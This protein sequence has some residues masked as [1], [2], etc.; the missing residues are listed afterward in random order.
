MYLAV[1]IGGT[2]TLVALLSDDGQ[3]VE[4]RRFQTDQDYQQF[5]TELRQNYA[6]LENRPQE[7]I[8]G[9]VGVP[10]A[11]DRDNGIVLALGN[12]PWQHKPIRDDIAA[13]TG[14]RIVIE[15]DAN[16]AGLSEAMLSK[17]YR[18]VL[19]FTV[20]TGI[21][22]GLIRDQ[23]IDPAFIKSEGG[24]IVLPH[25]GV[26]TDWEH[27]AS[28]K[29][30]AERYGKPAS[31]ITNENDWRAIARDLAPG[32]F[33]HIAI[34]QPDLIVIGGSIGT[35]FEHYKG[36]LLEELA[37]FERPVVPVPPITEAQRPEEAVVFGCYDL[38]RQVFGNG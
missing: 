24:H 16:L 12:L 9:G 32:F 21:G 30:I 37:A 36:Y 5:I 26:L 13:I 29:A 7:P 23:Q 25:K 8:D 28:G 38:A 4:Q 19:Y 3:I 10:G 2:K 15:N 20:S 14:G 35:H 34:I 27:Y 17:E 1:D 33:N 6:Q 22:T 31:E 18:T 11:L